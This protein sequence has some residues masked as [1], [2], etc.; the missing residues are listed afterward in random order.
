MVPLNFDEN[1]SLTFISISSFG[2]EV[3]FWAFIFLS[4]VILCWGREYKIDW[5]RNFI[6]QLLK[7]ARALQ[8]ME[9]KKKKENET[10]K[11][12]LTVSLLHLLEYAAQ[13]KR[14]G[15]R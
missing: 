8:A 11:K 9:I 4:L 15:K 7:G 2:E 6:L 3:M 1:L 5:E 14:E 10:I 12:Y 13:A